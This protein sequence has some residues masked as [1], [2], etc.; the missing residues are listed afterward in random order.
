M[1]VS[2]NDVKGTYWYIKKFVTFYYFVFVKKQ[3]D[4]NGLKQISDIFENY[5]ESVA[6]EVKDKAYEFFFE[7]DIRKVDEIITL[8][9]FLPHEH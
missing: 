5:C 8:L 9:F 7:R 2:R 4:R 1:E 6:T 3:L